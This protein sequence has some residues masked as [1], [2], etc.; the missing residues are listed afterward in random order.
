MK[1]MALLRKLTPRTVEGGLELYLN[2]AASNL[3]RMRS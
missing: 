3:V 2:R 1:D